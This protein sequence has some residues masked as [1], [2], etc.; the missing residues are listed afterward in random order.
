LHK[1]PT[2][3]QVKAIH[4]RIIREQGQAY[5]P[6]P[7]TKE[8]DIE[9]ILVGVK[10][11]VFG[12]VLYKTLC[13]KAIYILDNIQSS[14]AFPDGNKRVAL[15]TFEFFLQLN[16]SSLNNVSQTEKKRFMLNLARHRVSKEYAIEC[17][18]KGIRKHS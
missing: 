3:A 4:Y 10:Q 6:L 17:C 18:I 5:I 16:G 2:L 14:Q 8:S 9:S 7:K 13:D 11:V 1:I 15:A 12:K